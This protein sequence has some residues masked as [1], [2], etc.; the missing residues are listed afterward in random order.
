MF[1]ILQGIEEQHIPPYNQ[2]LFLDSLS[3]IPEKYKKLKLYKS[4]ILA[5][6]KL[7][8]KLYCIFM[9]KYLLT[10]V[11]KDPAEWKR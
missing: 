7:A 9:R 10:Y 6:K 3:K 5:D 8:L 4:F 11:L 1:G 2:T